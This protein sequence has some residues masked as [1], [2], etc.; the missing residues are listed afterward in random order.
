MQVRASDGTRLH[1]RVDG[2]P[3][4]PLTVVFSHGYVMTHNAWASQRTSLGEQLRLVSY[5]QRGHGRSEV[6][7]LESMTIDQLGADLAAV[8]EQTC[9]DGPVVL[10]GHSMG[11]MAI[12][13][14]AE[15]HPD[16]V[17]DRVAGA[18]LVT[19]SAGPVNAQLGIRPD[20]A[21]RV[22]RA[23]S[24]LGITRGCCRLLRRAALLA[25]RHENVA[26][27]LRPGLVDFVLQMT[28]AHPI[29]ALLAL[30]PE[31]LTHDKHA[32][33]PGL[34]RVPVLVVGADRDDT[35]APHASAAL[36]RAIP[37]ADLVMLD[38]AGHMAIVEH[39]HR[40]NRLLHDLL[41]RV[42]ARLSE[43]TPPGPLPA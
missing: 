6:G 23:F 32:A 13:A 29:E 33:L 18:A 40:I 20:I 4:A 39:P 5:D 10:I 8:L 19:T 11:G 26:T 1:A 9:P 34:G 30:V 41:A 35:I 16:L 25:D 22:L 7:E 27:R 12:M 36:A 24:R 38:D 37:G 17:G 3:D 14:L 2:D 21:N 42:R 28:R 43:L 15:Q 31:F